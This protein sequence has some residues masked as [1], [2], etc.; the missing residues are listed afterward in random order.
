MNKIKMMVG[1]QGPA[2]CRLPGQVLVVGVEIGAEEAQRLVDGHI[3]AEVREIPLPDQASTSTLAI[4]A[5]TVA[6]DALEP[7]PAGEPEPVVLPA[8]AGDPAQTIEPAP[9]TE[10]AP[11]EPAPV[12]PA[13]AEPAPAEPAPAE[14]APAEP[15]PAPAKRVRV[16]KPAAQG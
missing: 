15:A 5:S 16:K 8:T 7:A 12:E 13:P 3:A 2:I 11:A 1:Q 10:T 6:T 4:A 9:A 14:P